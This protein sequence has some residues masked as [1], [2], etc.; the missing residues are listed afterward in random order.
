MLIVGLVVCVF[1]A[2]FEKLIVDR[3]EDVVVT[4]EVKDELEVTVADIV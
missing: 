1:V 4:E 3:L 2:L